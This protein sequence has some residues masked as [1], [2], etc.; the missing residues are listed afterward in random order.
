[1]ESCRV[2]Y[3][4]EEGDGEAGTKPS[5]CCIRCSLG[6]GIQP[7]TVSVTVRFTVEE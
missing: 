3:L 1:M 7:V 4:R 6:R 2:V 5:T